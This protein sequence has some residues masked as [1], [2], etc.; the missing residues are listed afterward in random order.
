MP[1]QITWDSSSD[2]GVIVL[3]AEGAVATRVDLA[4][5][6]QVVRTLWL[7]LAELRN[8]R[9]EVAG[10][11]RPITQPLRIPDADERLIGVVRGDA[12]AVQ[13]LFPGSRLIPI[14]VDA[15]TADQ[16]REWDSYD[17][18][19]LDA[20]R[21]GSMDDRSIGRLLGAGVCIVALGTQPETDPAWP[22][23]QVQGLS[24]L[25]HGL[26][27]HPGSVEPAVTLAAKGLGLGWPGEVRT[28]LY[29]RMT[30][31]AILVIA[32]ALWRPRQ[33]AAVP[34]VAA[35]VI[36]YGVALGA[37]HERHPG[38]RHRIGTIAITGGTMT[39]LDTW[40]FVTPVRA[41]DYQHDVTVRPVMRSVDQVRELALSF[42]C[43]P[44]TDYAGI[45]RYTL[46]PG[47]VL[48][49]RER[50]VEQRQLARTSGDSGTGPD[51]A[52]WTRFVEAIYGP[53]GWSVAGRRAVEGQRDAFVESWPTLVMR[54]TPAPATTKP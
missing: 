49:T 50:A 25:E 37:W 54:R 42:E 39:L 14:T 13:P 1:V 28:Q 44:G 46:A 36:V 33:W 16:P 27:N 17:A 26:P 35:I 52:G 51:A 30:V 48:A 12:V 31:L 22:W 6:P 19:L 43:S 18:V 7:P 53:L 40:R 4:G 10:V 15:A 32:V 45:Y 47:Q 9:I 21:F 2:A 5:A 3:R 34:S 8:P 11:E 23:R 24:V 38:F 20:D 41:F 29:L